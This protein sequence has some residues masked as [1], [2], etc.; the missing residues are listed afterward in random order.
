MS[1]TSPRENN[2]ALLLSPRAEA[3][4]RPSTKSQVVTGM[5]LGRVHA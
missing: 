2:A 3:V 1:E 5:P 4:T